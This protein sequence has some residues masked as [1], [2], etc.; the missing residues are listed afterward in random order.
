M[1]ALL[2]SHEYFVG[3]HSFEKSNKCLKRF[4]SY[5]AFR[6]GVFENTITGI[7]VNLRKNPLIFIEV[8]RKGNMSQGCISLQ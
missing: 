7:R 5:M 6:I 8:G 4:C 3:I 1:W 2:E